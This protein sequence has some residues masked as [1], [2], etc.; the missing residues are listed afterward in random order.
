MR[1]TVLSVN[2][3]HKFTPYLP[4]TCTCL[5][6]I[7]QGEKQKPSQQLPPCPRALLHPSC[8]LPAPSSLVYPQL[9]I[10]HPLSSILHPTSSELFCHP[11]PLLP[12]PNHVAPSRA[13]EETPT[14]GTLSPLPTQA[15]GGDPGSAKRSG[16]FHTSP[17]LR[18][19]HHQKSTTVEPPPRALASMDQAGPSK[20]LPGARARDW[21]CNGGLQLLKGHGSDAWLLELSKCGFNNHLALLLYAI[22]I[23]LH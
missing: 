7:P 22:T 21:F 17:F 2:S 20:D 13:A 9:S 10:T 11:S 8:I 23:P 18:L 14:G 16:L 19:R 3:P 15:P 5:S 4:C 12:P 6:R 1:S